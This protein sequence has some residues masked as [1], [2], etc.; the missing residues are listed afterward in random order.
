[1]YGILVETLQVERHP[2]IVEVT[3]M[4]ILITGG[5]GYIG[6]H[7]AKALHRAG[8][9]PIVID[10]L[11]TGHRWAVNWGPLIEGDVSHADLV[12]H[13]IQDYR[14]EAIIHFAAS[15]EVAESVVNPHKYL[16]GNVRSTM[17]VLE[18]M[19]DTSVRNIIV[20]STCA[21]YGSPDVLPITENT[22]QHPVNPYGESKRFVERALEW[23]G[24][25][26]DIS[27]VALRYFNAAG[28][29]PDGEIG[30]EHDPESHVLPLAIKTA[31]GEIPAFHIMGTNYATPDGTAIRDFVHVCDLADGHIRALG[32]LLSGGQSTAMNLGT[33]R[34]VSVKQLVHTVERVIGRPVQCKQ[35]P[36]RPGD[37]PV[38]VASAKR[39]QDL[40]HW[41]PR[42]DCFDEIVKTA[43]AW[44][45]ARVP[46]SVGR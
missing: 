1:M 22:P 7:T 23:Y 36:R 42:F 21:V 43:A 18:A 14:V 19:R 35:S 5:A 9:R 16:S 13:V 27:W 6:S 17:G 33:G 30:E 26:H 38:L 15:A 46:V 28:A 32:Y 40:L 8:H 11:S 45:S 34:G 12:R 10:N 4:N 29:D 31:L 25:A 20:S 3:S 39:A 24:K 44:H 41:K 37:P 2:R